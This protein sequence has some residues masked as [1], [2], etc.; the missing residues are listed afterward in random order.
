MIHT[1]EHKKGN[2]MQTTFQVLTTNGK[3][4][5][6]NSLHLI[7]NSVGI[8]FATNQG[9][10]ENYNV[11]SH[12][13]ILGTQHLLLL[14]RLI[15]QSMPTMMALSI[16]LRVEV[17]TVGGIQMVFLSNNTIFTVMAHNFY[18][19]IPTLDLKSSTRTVNV[20]GGLL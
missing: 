2:L 10:C 8:M 15:H 9:K 14:V 3:M 18:W 5:A 4:L 6:Q 17:P 19:L 12:S 13:S 11:H 16:G 1:D 7:L 20:I